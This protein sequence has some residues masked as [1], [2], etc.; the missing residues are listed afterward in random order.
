MLIKLSTRSCLEIRMQD[1]VTIQIK[2]NNSSFESVE[3]FNYMGTLLTNQ[4]Y[5]QEEI[6]N[7]L[8]SRNACCHSV[9]TLLSSNLLSK[10]TKTK[11]HKQNY[12]IACC[13]IWASNLVAQI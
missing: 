13:F 5:I 6:K 1:E 4:S 9:Q 7:T 8:K 11:I 12:N 3:E 10:N 2:I